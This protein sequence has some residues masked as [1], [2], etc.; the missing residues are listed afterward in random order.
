MKKFLALTVLAAVMITA[1]AARTP[2]K[3]KS[4]TLESVTVKKGDS[5]WNLCYS[6][7]PDDMRLD[8]YISSVIK[9]N[10]LEGQD[11]IYPGDVLQLMV[12]GEE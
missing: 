7:C 2:E 9:L 3:E 6:K 12:Y 11:F 1:I 8:T 10:G 5:L 4:Y